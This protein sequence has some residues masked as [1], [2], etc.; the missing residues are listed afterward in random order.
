MFSQVEIAETFYELG[1]LYIDKGDL[2]KAE[3]KFRQSADVYLKLN[4]FKEYLSCQNKLLRVLVEM[5]RF[6]EVEIL[7]NQ[8]KYNVEAF[9]IEPSAKLLYTEAVF[10]YMSMDLDVADKKFDESLKKALEE[11]SK[12]DIC[13]ALFGQATV[14]KAKK[15]D[16]MV[17]KKLKNL[18]VFLDVI[19]ISD[20]KA[21][22][23]LFQAEIEIDKGN[24]SKALDL[25]WECHDVL[26]TNPNQFYRAYLFSCFALCYYYLGNQDLASH[27]IQL[28]KSSIDPLVHLNSAKM[29]ERAEKLMGQE[30]PEFDIILDKK[31]HSV[32]ERNK[33]AVEF[34]NQF[35]VL[36]MLKLF[37]NNPGKSF[38]KEELAEYVWQ[39][40]YDPRVHD[41]KIYVT[42]K[43]LRQLIEPE[44]NQP[45]YIF[46]SR[47]GY[48]LDK[49]TRVCI[50]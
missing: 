4:Y 42:V 35:I 32:I 13:N 2:S 3:P 50:N 11:D 5:G 43:R 27:H 40:E 37:V 46:R 20:V 18:E 39:Q 48:Y 44:V 34:N 15:L 25:V 6:K 7:S 41:N 12:E 47:K 49:S 23:K 36:E 30:Q 31:N 14:Y 28:A 19:E 1:C 22:T 10:A 38:S 16:D 17:E 8:I 24:Y 29:I 9:E 21:A 45:K 33:G 26:K